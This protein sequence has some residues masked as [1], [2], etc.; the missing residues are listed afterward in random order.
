MSTNLTTFNAQLPTKLRGQKIENELSAG[1]AAGFGLI[2]FKGKVWSVRYQGNTTPLMREDNDGPRNSI[3][4]VIVKASS[5]ISKIWYDGKYVEGS[6]AAPD[7]F[8]TNGIV[9]DPGAAKKQAPACAGCPKNAWG[10]RITDAGKQG[11]AC[12]DSKRLAVVWGGDL[13]NEALGGPMLLRVPAASLKDLAAYGDLLTS[14]G[15]IGHAVV[16]RIAFDPEAAFPQFKFSGVRAL[17]DAEYDVI[18]AWRNDPRT[19]RILAEGSES[20]SQAPVEPVAPVNVVPFAQPVPKAVVNPP[21]VVKSEPQNP[22]EP[23]IEAQIAALQ[24]QLAT[25]AELQAMPPKVNRAD[26]TPPVTPEVTDN[27]PAGATTD[28]EAQLDARINSL[29]KV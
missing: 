13:K 2:G 19:A 12:A 26:A 17:T 6:Q 3:E 1:I 4:V 11:K 14:Q 24:K 20:V 21:Q 22:G 28:F 29:L 18:D 23:S 27:T 10:S 25:R 8:S 9:P 7:C 16:T 5:H 15:L